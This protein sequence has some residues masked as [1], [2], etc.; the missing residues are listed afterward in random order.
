VR[1]ASGPGGN[2]E[3]VL[4]LGIMP[5]LDRGTTWID[6]V[7]AGRSAEARATLPLHWK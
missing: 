4:W 1:G 5:P 3:L 6:V 7:A 2:G